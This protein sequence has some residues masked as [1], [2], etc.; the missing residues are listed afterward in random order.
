MS[1]TLAANYQRLDQRVESVLDSFS[2]QF[3]AILARAQTRT[4]LQLRGLVTVEADGTI[5]PTA[6]NLKALQKQPAIFRQALE[7]EGYDRMVANFLG[8]FNGGLPALERILGEVSKSYEVS[9][10]DFGKQDQAFFDA[11]KGNTSLNLEATIELVSQNAR[12]LAM[13]TVGGVGFEELAVHIADRLH[14]ALGQAE[15]VAAT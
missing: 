3:A 12:Q 1:D 5:R 4:S 2:T 8:T 14:V 15:G 10:P 6:S 13:F 11:L 7:S 9:N